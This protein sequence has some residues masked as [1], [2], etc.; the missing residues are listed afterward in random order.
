MS[1]K[2]EAQSVWSYCQQLDHSLA[3]PRLRQD[4][5]DVI[6]TV[7]IPLEN[8]LVSFP[9]CP[10]LP[11]SPA[12]KIGIAVWAR[13]HPENAD[14]ELLLQYGRDELPLVRFAAASALQVTSEEDNKR[15]KELSFA[16]RA[17]QDLQDWWDHE[18]SPS[19]SFILKSLLDQ[20]AKFARPL[21]RPRAPIRSNP[22]VAGVPIKDADKFF[23][24]QETLNEI[25]AKL[26][27]TLGVKS[28]ILYG[29]RRSGK[30]S[31]LLRIKSGALGTS[32]VPVYVDMQGFAG[33]DANVFLA[34]LAQA[35]VN[36]VLETGIQ[37]SQQKS[38]QGQSPKFI[39]H[40]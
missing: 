22:Y 32:F 26:G 36:A 30:T 35:T 10:E 8:M 3:S 27:Q 2:P 39:D 13:L 5:P 29:A 20:S 38:A 12:G 25:A 23:G 4:D 34:S 17:R 18:Q 14:L 21:R 40:D 9:E 6:R 28:L 11:D 16:A 7:I 33:V 1:S 15:W 24:R 37:V 31:I 19:I